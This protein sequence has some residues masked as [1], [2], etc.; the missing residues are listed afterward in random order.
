MALF[1]Y[2]N[3]VE[4]P[5]TLLIVSSEIPGY[6]AANL[7]V[8]LGSSATAW[9]TA[10][11]VTSASLTITA[12]AAV[13][14]RAVCLARTSLTTAATMRVRVGSVANINTTPNYDSGVVS[15]GVAVGIGQALHLLPTATSEVAMI[16]D[17]AD[18]ANPDGLLNIPLAYAGPATETPLSPRSRREPQLRDADTTTRG[19]VVLAQ[20]LSRARAWQIEL[21]MVPDATSG[22]LDAMEAAAGARRNILFVPRTPHARAA[23]ESVFGLVRSGSRGFLTATGR[24]LTFSA[25][26]SERL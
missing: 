16:I 7:R 3:A 17:I 13:S 14:W 20:P 11:G 8:P 9:Q 10:P 18:T 21:G 25:S 22:W 2:E 5:S 6:L 23:A 1:G 15:A 26:I 19:G 12:A 4:T 24:N